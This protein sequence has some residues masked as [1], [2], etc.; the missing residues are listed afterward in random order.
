MI[1]DRATNFFLAIPVLLAA[2]PFAFGQQAT[3]QVQYPYGYYA[4]PNY[5]YPPPSAYAPAPNF[6]FGYN[7]GYG[8]NYFYVQN[9]YAYSGP[10]RPANSPPPPAPLNYPQPSQPLPPL[11]AEPANAAG[12]VNGDGDGDPPADAPALQPLAVSAGPP[13]NA[14]G[15]TPITPPSSCAPC[16]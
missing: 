15:S 3:Q 4:A 9:P 14:S 11:P 12:A 8:V 2:A 1:W 13:T 7:T 5:A 6:N 10:Y 16:T